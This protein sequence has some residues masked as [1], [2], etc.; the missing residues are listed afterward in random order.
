MKILMHIPSVKPLEKVPCVVEILPADR[1]EEPVIDKVMNENH[2]SHCPHVIHTST[3]VLSVSW[4]K[5][6]R[7]SMGNYF[8]SGRVSFSFGASFSV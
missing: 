1:I 2:Q 4:V 6:F 8:F 3:V 7:V 5:G